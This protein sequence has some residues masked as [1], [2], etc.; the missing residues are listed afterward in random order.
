M[1]RKP[2]ALGEGTKRRNPKGKGLYMN[3][4][5]KAL[6]E[7]VGDNVFKKVLEKLKKTFKYF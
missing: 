6:G 7:G 4:K 1:N 3:R 5:A 2:K